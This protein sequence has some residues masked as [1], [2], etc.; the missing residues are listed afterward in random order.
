M[1]GRDRRGR[2]E[3]EPGA[4]G[5]G[6]STVVLVVGSGTNPRRPAEIMRWVRALVPAALILVSSAPMSAPASD[7]VITVNVDELDAG[8]LAIAAALARP[9]GRD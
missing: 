5:G 8:P 9:R 3:R 4:V 6:V 7:D 2:Q 1:A